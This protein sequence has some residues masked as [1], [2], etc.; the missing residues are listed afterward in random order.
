[1]IIVRPMLILS[2]FVQEIAKKLLWSHIDVN[3][4]E[5]PNILL[6]KYGII[7]DESIRG[8][9][10]HYPAISVD[11]YV[12]MPNHIHLRLQINSNVDGRPMAAPTISTVVNHLKGIASKRTG[13]SLWQK[14]FYD[15]IIRGEHDY[16]E[17]WN[18]ITGNPFKWTE[19]QYCTL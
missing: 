11:N 3:P 5:E 1:M 6:S 12:I 2:Q 19:D 13:L 14:G 15:H 7:V 16:Q 4:I 8:I 18:Y 9:P 17:I 10:A